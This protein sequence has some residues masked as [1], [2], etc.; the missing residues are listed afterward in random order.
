L[1]Q[2]EWGFLD[3]NLG[4]DPGNPGFTDFFT[5]FQMFSK[6]PGE[7]RLKLGIQ[8]IP[9]FSIN[10]H[11]FLNLFGIFRGFWMIFHRKTKI[12]SWKIGK[13]LKNPRNTRKIAKKAIF[14]GI[15]QK[16]VFS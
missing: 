7:I 5:F 2:G 11:I 13:T 8:E 6:D 16:F 4:V 10:F 12:F 3:R 15:F 14:F 1:G 9:R